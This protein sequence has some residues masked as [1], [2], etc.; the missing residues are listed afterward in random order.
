M[1]AL[2][3]SI[4]VLATA[5]TALACPP[6]ARCVVEAPTIQEAPRASLRSA[7][8]GPKPALRLDIELVDTRGPWT[9]DAP[10]KT[11]GIEMPWIWQA[12]RAQVYDH[13]PR[14]HGEDD[15]TFTLSP[16]VVAGSF[17]TV[18]GIGIAGDF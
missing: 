5:R 18:P 10:K 12:L 16:V 1:R 11:D 17:D 2:V 8:P 3:V 7:P 4:I 6:G 14:Y 13:M 15:L 9:F